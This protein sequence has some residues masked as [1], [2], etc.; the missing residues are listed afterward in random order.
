MPTSASAG[1]NGQVYVSIDAG[2]T[3]IPVGEVKDCTVTITQD[4]LDATSYDSVGWKERIVGLKS[5]EMSME[6]L[7]INQ[8]FRGNIGQVNLQDSLLGG[9][10]VRWQVLPLRGYGDIGYVGDGFVN[11]WACNI[12]VDDV[13]SLSLNVMGSGYLDTYQSTQPRI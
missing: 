8:S 9:Q 4:D 2:L 6:A 7:Y 12:P 11:S 3:F 10:V 13:V 5:W 1:F